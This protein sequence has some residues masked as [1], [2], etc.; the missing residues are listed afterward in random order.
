MTATV[1]TNSQ[2]D[3]Q[4]QQD[5]AHWRA[6][7]G[8]VFAGLFGSC[9][10]LGTQRRTPR[11]ASYDYVRVP[12]SRRSGPHMGQPVPFSARCAEK[13]RN[14]EFSLVET[15]RSVDLLAIA[16]LE[17]GTTIC[18]RKLGSSQLQL[19]SLWPV[20][21][22]LTC[23]AASLAQL[24]VSSLQK[25]LEQTQQ[26][27]LLLALPLV[28][29]VTTLASAAPHAKTFRATLAR[30]T[31]MNSRQGPSLAAVLRSKDKRYV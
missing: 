11:L 4:Y 12:H 1:G 25:F 18:L 5:L 30:H 24:A 23:S 29:S 2:S 15:A 6:G 17:K 31:I 3:P 22:K 9:Q 20:V 14:C 10:R 19:H 21:W 13:C 7:F 27:L 28:C 8:D 16:N 26:Q